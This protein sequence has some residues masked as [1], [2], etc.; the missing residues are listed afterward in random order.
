[1]SALAEHGSSECLCDTAT[2][3]SEGSSHLDQCSQLS[4]RGCI[5]VVPNFDAL[6]GR[7]CMSFMVGVPEVNRHTSWRWRIAWR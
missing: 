5:Q 4:C 6:K 7:L 1:M 3:L 2:V